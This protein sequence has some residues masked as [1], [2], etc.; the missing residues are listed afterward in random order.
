MPIAT[1]SPPIWGDATKMFATS[2]QLIATTEGYIAALEAA[3]GQLAAPTINPIFP[4]ITTPPTPG[5]ATAPTLQTV[6]W[7][8]PPQPAPFA[9]VLN[10]G[11]VLPGPFTGNPPTLNFPVA[12]A[13]FNLP[14]PSSPGVNLNFT[15]PTPSVA[16]PTPPTLLGLDIVNFNIGAIPQFNVNVPTLNLNPPSIIPYNEPALFTSQ[17]LTDLE[18]SLDQAIT[19]G[20][21]T[22]LPPNIETNLFDRARDREYRAQADAL[23][24]LN[25]METLGYAFPPGVFIDAR[26]K[27]QSETQYTIATLSRE[28]M[29]KQ[30][31]LILENTIKARENATAL[32]SK[33][34]DY[35]NQIAQ[36]TFESAKYVTEAAIALY[37]AGVQA[38]VASLDGYR[39]EALV[40]DTQIKGILAQVDVLKAQIAFEQTKA[41]IN[42]ALVMQYKT[43]VDAALAIVQIY[44][45][46]VKIIQTEAE[47]EKIKVEIYGEQIKAYTGQIQAFAAQVDAY[48]VG[49]ESQGVIESVYKT[50]VDAYTS[51]VNAGVAEAN[52]LIAVFKGQIDAYTAQLDG[53]KAAI[54]GMIGQAQAAS[55]FN[56]ASADVYR[57]ASSAIGTYNN[58]LTA[59]WQA[60][61][62][63]QEKIAEVAVQAAKANGDLYIAARG[64]SLDA[65]KV[66]AQVA[67]QLGAAALGAI[68]WANSSS[69][70]TSS[71][72]SNAES[73]ATNT[74]TNTNIGV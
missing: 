52:A 50:Q 6:T 62:N 66:G 37:N 36:R 47:V 19:L 61:L 28:I 71:T 21:W 46:Q 68:H 3:A 74:N 44:E 20:T 17:L 63:E 11:N 67:A 23:E 15:Y 57:A 29:T 43:E 53:Y 39:T 22:G 31:E 58:T 59:Q 2:Q 26:V 72:D 16:L 70:A 34:I 55:L 64:L 48:K 42:T 60:V 33:L 65:S 38:Y 24:E 5:V 12:P 25:R 69:W 8:V 10:I 7:T 56:T 40:Y 1:V 4:V 35:A 73:T 32:E 45:L 9:G 30:A 51:T 49:V 27:L 14:A 18:A 41:E 13:G 54:T